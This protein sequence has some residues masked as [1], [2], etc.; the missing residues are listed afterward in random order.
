MRRGIKKLPQSTQ[1][2]DYLSAFLRVLC[3]K[4]LFYGLPQ[5]F[6]LHLHPVLWPQGDLRQWLDGESRFEGH[7]PALSEGCQQQGAFHPG[8]GFANAQA[9]TRTKG[10][11]GHLRAGRCLIGRP[12][13]RVEPQRLR[14]VL[15]VMVDDPLTEQNRRPFWQNVPTDFHIFQCFTGGD[16]GGRVETHGF[17]QDHARVG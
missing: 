8:K 10:E 5:P 6:D 16:P 3:G 12:T 4:N 14:V 9:R 2:K 11:V 1:R 13:I 17:A 15:L 7:L